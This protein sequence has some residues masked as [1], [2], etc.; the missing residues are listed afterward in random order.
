M[1]LFNI[2]KIITGLFVLA[3]FFASCIKGEVDPIGDAGTPMVNFSESPSRVQYFAPF[4]DSKLVDLVTIRR[5]EIRSSDVDQSYTLTIVADAAALDAYNEEHDTHFEAL[6]DSIY[7][8]VAGKG[9]VAK[10]AG[11]YEVTFQPGVTAIPL[12][13][14]IDGSKWDVSKTY[15]F[16]FVFKDLNGKTIKSDQGEALAAVAIINEWD[17]IYTVEDGNVQR[18]TAPGVPTTDDL[19]G[20]MAGNSDVELATINTTTVEIHGLQWAANG[21]GIGGIDNLQIVIDPATNNVTMK[22]LGNATLRNIAGQENS[23]DPVSRTFTLNF[24]WNPTAN[25]REITNLVLKYSEPR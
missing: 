19:N 9:V 11:V 4:E 6:P 10:E 1:K 24:E 18:Y 13:V 17:G 14:N 5:D 8:L 21:G 15:G 2:K 25:K 20:S 22:C 12:T 23:Y 16:Y 7:T 3:T